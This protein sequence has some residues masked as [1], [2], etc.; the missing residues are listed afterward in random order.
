MDEFSCCFGCPYNILVVTDRQLQIWIP[1]LNH[2][3]K[4][5]ASNPNKG[6]QMTWEHESSTFI[7]ASTGKWSNLSCGQPALYKI[8]MVSRE[9]FLNFLLGVISLL[10]KVKCNQIWTIFLLSNMKQNQLLKISF[11]WTVVLKTRK[12]DDFWELHENKR[13]MA[14]IGVNTNYDLFVKSNLASLLSRRDDFLEIFE[15]VSRISWSLLT[16]QCIK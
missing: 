9:H 1:G 14:T 7:F 10:L 11:V 13:E 16:S 6:Y 12:S 5:D 15:F 4:N 8:Q 3:C 2:A